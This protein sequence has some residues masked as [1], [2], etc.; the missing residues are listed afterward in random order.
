[1]NGR[2]L[3][4]SLP[5]GMH[6]DSHACVAP[7]SST[8]SIFLHTTVNEVST[9]WGHILKSN[10]NGTYFRLSLENVNRNIGGFVDFQRFVRLD[11]IAMAII[12]ANPVEAALTGRKALQNA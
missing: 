2:L 7:T 6:S 8:K 12:V 4:G 5:P 10:S 1:M 11:G 3:S 9:P